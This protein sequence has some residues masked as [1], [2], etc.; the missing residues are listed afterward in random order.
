MTG[1][2]ARAALAGSAAL[3]VA[4]SPTMPSPSLE[5]CDDGICTLR[6]TAP[7]L[8][9]EAEKLVTAKRYAEARPL[10]AALHSAPELSM[11]THFLEGFVATETGQYDEAAKDFRAILRDRPDVTRARLELAR[12]LMLQGKD[13]AA[14]HH[15]RLAEED[16]DLPPEIQRTISEAR[17]IIRNRKNWNF[18]L[19]VGFAP[20]SN[21]N[22]ATSARLID[23]IYGNNTIELD[24]QARARKGIGQMLGLSG[25][26]RLRLGD[27]KAIL[28][29]AD[30]QVINQRGTSADDISALIAAGPELTMKGGARLSVQALGVRRWYGGKIAQ[31][32]GGARIS[33]QQPLA[34]G[35]RLGFQIDG[36][37][38]ES[39]YGDAYAGWQTSAYA[40][41]E[42]VVRHS[43][44]ASATLFAR[45]EALGLDA[46][47]NSE[48]GGALGIGGELP[49]GINAGLS[50]GISR[51]LF[52]DPLPILSP[53]DRRDWRFNARAYLGARSVRVLGFSP[54]LTYTYNRAESS[55]DLYRTSRH[56]LQVGL[57]RYF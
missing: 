32:G 50:G 41:Y 5:A 27:G 10:L 18:N 23:S 55:L 24:E 39:G 2:M 6:M 49:L 33:Y 7:Q 20:D 30:G 12:V 37:R 22:N 21:V 26:V 54:S 45:R 1:R 48:F 34:Q 51:V 35:Q 29:D 8:L 40:T 44:V 36:R 3:L 14:D 11:E 42:R 31:S 25:G 4:W 38:V 46:Y 19:D 13:A 9:E 16:S 43:L 56:R 52:D 17:S 28:I 53:D 15:F 57:A 47:S